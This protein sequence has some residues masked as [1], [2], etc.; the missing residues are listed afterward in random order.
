MV[1]YRP[2]LLISSATGCRVFF[3]GGRNSL[4]GGGI[5]KEP[6]G[7]V[8]RL[9]YPQGSAKAPGLGSRV[10]SSLMLPSMHAHSRQARP[11][12]SQSLQ[13]RRHYCSRY[14]VRGYEA[15]WQHFG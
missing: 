8:T 10:T 12:P 15:M 2:G 1:A 14:S 9:R 13:G 3:L 5:V 7:T 4:T 11:L 6:D